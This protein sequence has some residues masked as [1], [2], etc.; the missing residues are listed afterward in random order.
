MPSQFEQSGQANQSCYLFPCFHGALQCHNGSVILDPWFH[1]AQ[2]CHTGLLFPWG[3]TVSHWSLVSMSPCSVT[4]LS[5]VL[6]YHNGPLVPWGL[7]M[8]E[9]SPW[10]HEALQSPLIQQASKCHHGL[11]DSMRPHSVTMD[12]WFHGVLHCSMNP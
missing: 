6:Q 7:T 1:E 10:F 11:Q 3:S 8:A 2:L 12:L 4:R 9:G 5:L